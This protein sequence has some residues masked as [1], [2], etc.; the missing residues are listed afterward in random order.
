[1]LRLVIIDEVHERSIDTDILCLLCRRL[2]QS[3]PTIRL[4][5]MSATMAAEL[6]SQYFGSPEP[7]IHVGA[8]RFPIKEYFV[9]DLSKLLSLSPKCSKL[10]K[11]V[12]D[13]SEKSKCLSA[14][15]ANV[16][17]KLY[18]LAAQIAGSV[19]SQGSSVLIF[20]PGM[21][22][23]EAI[24]ELIERLSVRGVDFLCLPIHSDVPFEEQM[25][26]FEPP[27]QGEVKVII[28]TNAAESSLT[29]P[30]VDHVICL[31]LCKQIIYNKASHR[32]M[33]VPTWISRA[34]ATQRAGRTGRGEH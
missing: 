19:G 20:V 13:Q 5:L 30:D 28:A 34:S 6:Y 7:P 15:S 22:D 33:L 26:A 21:S 9:E 17:E 10:A 23:I 3:H 27:K 18:N 8:R 31:G 12:F 4:V 1:M 24:I 2:L 14:P 32:Q 25:A 16:M 29:L 11:E